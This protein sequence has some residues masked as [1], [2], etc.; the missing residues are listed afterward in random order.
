[1]RVACASTAGEPPAGS[2]RKAS[3]ETMSRGRAQA[4]LGALLLAPLL[5]FQAGCSS[6]RLAYDNADTLLRW[7]AKSYLD[8]HGAQADELDARIAAFLAWHRKAALP[9]YVKLATEA[10]ARVERGL[11]RE[12]LVWGYD[13]TIRELRETLRH[14]IGE[15]TELLD[16]LSEEQIVHLES[17]FAEDNRDFER[18]HLSG[19]PQKR[20]KERARRVVERLED[21]VGSLSDAQLERV[22]L[23]SA[24]APLY[25]EQR[26]R[27]YRRRQAEFVAML[28]A[29]QARE[30]LADWALEWERGR[31]PAY[32]AMVLAERE[33]LFD[34]LFDIDR[35]LSAEQR[36]R[37]AA[38]FRDYAADFARLAA[39]GE[40]K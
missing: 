4:L 38:R 37:A 9:E 35:T 5:V 24:R 15:G 8:I 20:R 30:R 3:A 13:S 33:E 25:D 7:E 17:R 34:M 39:E 40:R 21:W 26:D 32:Q 29:H 1:M 2:P 14:A 12:D 23:Y 28:R 36:A 6:V 10:A 27:E 31:S 19:T 11:S 18:E 16:R 22:A